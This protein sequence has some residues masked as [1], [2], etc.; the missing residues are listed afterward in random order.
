MLDAGCLRA[1]ERV[2][3]DEP[4]RSSSGRP[5]AR[6]LEHRALGR[7]RRRSRRS[8]RRPRAPRARAPASA[9]TGAHTK[10]ASAPATAS[11]TVAHALSTA[12]RSSARCERIRVR[13]EAAAPRAP[14]TRA[15][16]ASPIEP[17]IRPTPRSA[18]LSGAAGVMSVAQSADSSLPTTAATR[19]TCSTYCGELVRRHRLRPVA[20]RRVGIVVH[21]DDDPVGARARRPPATAAA[22]GRAARQRGSGRRP[23]AGATAASAPARP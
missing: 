18:I 12:P 16:A 21:L 9:P 2:P 6:A 22:P 20:D 8:P 10:H 7:A 23:P 1:G 11:A 5:E 14:S 4:R 15:R 19:C 13:V 17:P 3:A